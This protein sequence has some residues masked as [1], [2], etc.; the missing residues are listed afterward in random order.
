[1]KSALPKAPAPDRQQD[2]P[3]GKVNLVRAALQAG[4]SPVRIARDFGVAVAAV[5]RLRAT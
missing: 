4:F 1:L 2:I 3:P 5:R